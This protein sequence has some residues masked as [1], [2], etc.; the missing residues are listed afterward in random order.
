MAYR[1]PLA[2]NDIDAAEIQ[3]ATEVLNSGL[4]TQGSKVAEFERLLAERHGVEHAIMVNSGSSA[5]L[6]AIEAIVHL[7]RL[8]PDLLPQRLDP[9]DEVIIQ[10]LNWPSTIKPITNQGL[11]PVFC[12]VD[13]ESLNASVETVAAVRTNKT[14]MVIAV[15]V[16][17][18]PTHLDGLR[19][20]CASE[21]LL[22][23][24]DACESLGATTPSGSVIGAIGTTSAFSFYFSHHLTTI[25]GGVVL[26]QD[27]RLA[28]LCRA[29]RAHGWSRNLQ[30]DDFLDLDADEVDPRF[31]FVL[32]GYNVRSTELNAAIGIVQ[33][34]KL[35]AAL[36]N[37]ARIAADRIAAIRSAG[38]QIAV[39]GEAS[40]AGHSWMT[41]P[42]LYQDVQARDRARVSLERDGIETRPIIVGNILRQPL[43]RTLATAPHQPPL[44]ACDAVFQRGLMIGLN[45]ASP[46]PVEA[47]VSEAIV[48]SA[49]G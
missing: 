25:E 28:D 17:G 30:L 34:A 45:P 26:T 3:A 2:H 41:F 4:L 36:A 15:P 44:P 40:S 29:L 47:F 8:R 9:G 24:E 49:H 46:P 13:L 32:P 31:C 33:L 38:V 27:A 10:G 11:V 16:L 35:D 20:Y 6:I 21:G 43:A 48:K 19:T 14:K 37:R 39:P 7:S 18:N 5:N 1:V 42:L 12:D 23:H 22:L